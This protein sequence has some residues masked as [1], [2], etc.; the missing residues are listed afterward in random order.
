MIPLKE[1]HSMDEL[2]QAWENSLQKPIIL[3]KHSTKCPI[4]A[5]AFLEYQ[6]FLESQEGDIECYMVKVIEDRP[7]SNEIEAMTK[8][9]HESPQILLVKNKEVLWHRSH[10]NITKASIQETLQK[11]GD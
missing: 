10:S 11:V 2:H 6:S 9:K 4:S 8:V 3:F 1:L 5:R 7:I